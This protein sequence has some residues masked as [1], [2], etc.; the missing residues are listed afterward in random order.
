MRPR[1]TATP[2]PLWCQQTMVAH[3]PQ[4]PLTADV[5]AL[6]PAETSPDLAVALTSERRLLEHL[7]DGFHQLVVWDLGLRAGSASQCVAT[8]TTVINRR[9]GCTQHGTH[10]AQWKIRFH[11]ILHRQFADLAF[12]LRQSTVA[13][14][15]RTFL[16]QPLLARLQ[17]VIPP[18]RQTMSPQHRPRGRHPRS[19]H[20]ATDEEPRRSC[21]SPT[22]SASTGTPP[23]RYWIP[24]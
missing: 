24:T 8:A 3:Q 21:G 17:K 11:L 6:L 19:T 1:P 14:R 4:H 7:T 5:D 10:P 13:L 12:R 15:L 22:I 2:N 16:F 18:G 23:A 20:T 9:P